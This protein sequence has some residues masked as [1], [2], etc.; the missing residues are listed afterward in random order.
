MSYINE[1]N[2]FGLRNWLKLIERMGLALKRLF[3]YTKRLKEFFLILKWNLFKIITI[4]QGMF[5]CR[6]MS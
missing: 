2:F 1:F 4:L 6:G 5:K 3:K